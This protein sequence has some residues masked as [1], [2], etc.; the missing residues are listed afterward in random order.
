M[1]DTSKVAPIDMQKLVQQIKQEAKERDAEKEQEAFQPADTENS[2]LTTLLSVAEP[3]HPEQ[4]ISE[5][6]AVLPELHHLDDFLFYEGRDF[7]R[8]AYIGILLREPDQK[9]MDNNLKFLRLGGSRETVLVR[10]MLSDEGQSKAVPIKG[11]SQLITRAKKFEKKS[12]VINKLSKLVYFQDGFFQRKQA[13]TSRMHRVIKRQ[14]EKNYQQQEKNHQQLCMQIETSEQK[15][16]AIIREVLQQQQNQR[17]QIQVNSE[18]VMGQLEWQLQVAQ[19][20]Q[21]HYKLAQ[22][23]SEQMIEKLEQQAQAAQSHLA[24][25]RRQFSYQQRNQDLFLQQLISENHQKL[26]ALAEVEKTPESE[27]EKQKFKQW[28]HLLEQHKVDKLDAYYIAFEDACR[29]TREEIR[30]NLK[31]YLPLLAQTI[32][33]LAAQENSNEK[34]LEVLDLGCGR[35]EWLQLLNEN[36]WRTAGI[37]TNKIMVQDCLNADLNVEEADATIYLKQQAADTVSVITAFHM[38][39]HIPFADLL[40]L[41]EETIRILK[42][43]GVI[44]FETP[45]PENILVGS[46]TFYHDST[47]TN[48]LTPTSMEFLARYTGFSNIQIKR[49]H[50]Y[51]D[52]AKVS[53]DD[54]LTERVNGHLCGPQDYAII[55]KKPVQTL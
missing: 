42:P 46:H 51:P 48:P 2:F 33:E 13:Q 39:E 29:G 20:Q 5:Q 7:V 55:A 17:N 32:P 21:N 11:M 41:F 9:G 43:G 47:H 12:W 18:A 31:V 3:G 1:N 27:Q 16:A 28:Q 34:Q 6:S 36:N 23:D 40:S 22:E 50:P 54:P 24:E 38:I 15:N 19:E 8:Y 53:G 4:A 26:S 30:N 35:G 45:N 37:D 14:Q 10:L 44:I 25:V 52:A 49:L